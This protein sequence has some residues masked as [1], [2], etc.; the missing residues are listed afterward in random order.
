MP[1]LGRVTYSVNYVVDLDNKDMVD[2]AK[3][4]VFE[5]VMNAVKYDE[6]TN[7][8]NVEDAPDADPSDIPEF[9]LKQ[10]DDETEK[11]KT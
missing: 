1:R 9:L 11:D 5:D 7:W 8:I 4:C 3:Q 2:E 10:N 6:V